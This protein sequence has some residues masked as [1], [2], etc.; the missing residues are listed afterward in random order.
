MKKWILSLVLLKVNPFWTLIAFF[1]FYFASLQKHHLPSYFVH[2]IFFQLILSLKLF[3]FFL[4]H[5]KFDHNIVSFT[6]WLHLYVW[7]QTFLLSRLMNIHCIFNLLY[8][9]IMLYSF[10]YLS[11]NLF[12]FLFKMFISITLPLKTSHSHF[13]FIFFLIILYLFS[14]LFYLLRLISH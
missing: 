9:L 1:I 14:S 3:C 13:Y 12:L 2:F 5:P 11:N 7:L 8:H 6:I 4:S 10:S